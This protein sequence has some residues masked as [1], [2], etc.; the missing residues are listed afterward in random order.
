MNQVALIKAPITEDLKQF[1]ALFATAFDVSDE[2]LG[3]V[4]THLS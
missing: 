1:E 3:S 2:L 4:P